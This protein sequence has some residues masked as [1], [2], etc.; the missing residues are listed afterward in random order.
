MGVSN[1][2]SSVA[3]TPGIDSRR[4]IFKGGFYVEFLKDS[5]ISLGERELRKASSLTSKFVSKISTCVER[6]K[7]LWQVSLTADADKHTGYPPMLLRNLPPNVL[8]AIA[9]VLHS[10]FLMVDVDIYTR[11]CHD[12]EYDEESDVVESGEEDEQQ[13]DDKRGYRQEAGDWP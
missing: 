5:S 8:Q 6:K 4:F 12:E 11:D 10:T 3:F 2:L 9:G 13:D 1:Y 7:T